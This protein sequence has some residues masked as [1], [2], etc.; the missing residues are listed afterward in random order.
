M[1]VLG[2]L[3]L[4]VE[5]GDTALPP[6]FERGLPASPD[7]LA[8]LF[9]LLLEQH[10][11]GLDQRLCLGGATLTFTDQARVHEVLQLVDQVVQVL[12]ARERTFVEV[13][14]G[15]SGKQQVDIVKGDWTPVPPD[16]G[17]PHLLARTDGTPPGHAEQDGDTGGFD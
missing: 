14:R 5:Q 4:T 11:P 9:V 6:S 3:Q 10:P 7:G 16:C 13:T 8:P 1:A 17:P 12:R 2:T 15:K